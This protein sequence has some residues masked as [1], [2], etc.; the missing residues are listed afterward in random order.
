M[1]KEE[2]DKIELESSNQS[3]KGITSFR[4][5]CQGHKI[6][7]GRDCVFFAPMFVKGKGFWCAKKCK[8]IDPDDCKNTCKEFEE[9]I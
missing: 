2:E 6:L 4:I 1:N 7:N 8:Y 5:M 3:L 9:R